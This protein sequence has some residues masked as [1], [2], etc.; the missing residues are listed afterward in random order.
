MALD[1]DASE[2]HI[3]SCSLEVSPEEV[4]GQAAILSP[5]ELERAQ[6]FRFERDR[7]RF[8][9]GR[10]VLRH[11]LG[12]YLRER[13][14]H[15]TFSYGT[16]GKPCLA[17]GQTVPPLFFNASHS[18]DVAVYAIAAV[19]LLGIDVER[20]RAISDLDSIADRFFSPREQTALARLQGDAKTE[21]FFHC[22]T[23]KEAILK[24]VGAGLSLP[25]DTLDVPV[26]PEAL[27]SVLA[28]PRTVADTADWSLHD[29]C[30]PTGYVGAVALPG[31]G[32]R[33]VR[34]RYVP[35]PPTARSESAA[36]R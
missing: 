33:V 28:L 13:P 9:V 3:W 24:A 36:R 34:T 27:P 30:P 14:E 8:I 4:G 23:R 12:R 11:I 25:L 31:E 22:W 2:I 16:H 35:D 7:R 10:S 32:W 20:I 15:L 26:A 18:D 6:R 29:V 17:R 5:D 21:A 1:L 19:D